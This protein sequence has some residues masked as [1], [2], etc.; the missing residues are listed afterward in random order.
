M[1]LIQGWIPPSRSNWDLLCR[2][3]D[4]FPLFTTVQWLTTWYPMGKTSVVS[5]LNIPGKWAWA[6]M[7]TPGFCLLLYNMYTLP[8]SLGITSLPKENWV[9]AGMFTLHY[10]NRALLSPLYLNPSMSPIHPLVWI[11][12]LSFQFS[13]ATALGGWLAGYG[14][15]T[16][17]Y[18]AGRGT[19]V[20]VGAAIWLCGLVGNVY[21]DEVLRRL[22]REAARKQEKAEER[23]KRGVEKV[24]LLPEDG[25]FKWILYP[26]YVC[27]WV[28]WTGYWVMAGWGCG[29]ARAFVLNEVF[30]ML[31]RAVQGKEWY[32]ER[33]GGEK[34]GGRGSVVP[35]IL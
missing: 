25:L 7:E 9:M 32:V 8:P 11:A 34:V 21:H 20:Y 28:E 23:G 35:G 10:L 14:P 4:F 17:A 24:Y 1:P 15:T 19:Q 29:P 18:W 13:N 2:V 12:A 33:F 6:T 27:E 22:R 30:S 3:W 5:R 16:G 31:P 26:H